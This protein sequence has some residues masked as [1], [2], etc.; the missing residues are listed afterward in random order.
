MNRASVSQ[1]ESEVH[2]WRG[3]LREL[4]ED[5]DRFAETL[6]DSERARAARIKSERTR[7]GFVL[8]RGLLRHVLSTYV[9]RSP[10]SLGF[11]TDSEGKPSLTD[12][13][14]LEFS[15]SSSHDLVLI[16]VAW[17]RK[18][19]V[20]IE[21]IDVDFDFQAVAQ[22]WFAPNECAC[23][24]KLNP[25]DAKNAFFAFWTRKEAYVK[26]LG[27]GL[28]SL[29]NVEVPLVSP[30]PILFD[31]GDRREELWDWRLHDL[32]MGPSYSAALAIHGHDNCVPRQV[33]A[34][35]LTAVS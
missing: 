14:R 15:A 28:R 30:A 23:L 35:G 7:L 19:G 18:V 31:H 1:L 27:Q 34:S 22:R 12:A 13:G 3:D 26:A 4:S 17:N 11:S 29:P 6:S 21:Y 9:E 5:Q 33:P 20:D 32:P 2:V 10:E 16:A 24:M 25:R 8:R